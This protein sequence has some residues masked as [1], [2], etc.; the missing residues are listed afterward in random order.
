MVMVIQALGNHCHL[1]VI[2]VTRTSS[3][4]FPIHIN[5]FFCNASK[6]LALLSPVNCGTSNIHFANFVLVQIICYLRPD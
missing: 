1:L 5:L 6:T 2:F 4:I 3:H